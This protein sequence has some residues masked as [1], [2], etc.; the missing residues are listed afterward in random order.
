MALTYKDNMKRFHDHVERL[1]YSNNVT[2]EPFQ[3]DRYLVHLPSG[4]KVFAL[5]S[6]A[7]NSEEYKKFR[8]EQLR[9][10]VEITPFLLE[11]KGP[12]N[13]D[14]KQDFLRYFLSESYESRHNGSLSKYTIDPNNK[15]PSKPYISGMIKISRL[16]KHLCTLKENKSYGLIYFDPEVQE[17][18][19]IIDS[20][21][22]RWFKDVFLKGKPNNDGFRPVNLSKDYKF[23]FKTKKQHPILAEILEQGA[24][25][26]IKHPF[27]ERI[28]RE[29]ADEEERRAN[30][31]LGEL[32]ELPYENSR[33][34]RINYPDLESDT[35][36]AEEE[37]KL[38]SNWDL[39]R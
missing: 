28:S 33:E 20:F 39:S 11:Q 30:E 26:E 27:A 19:Q 35:L 5:L 23:P 34:Q 24:K 8:S 22:N 37:Q 10:G 25:W 36:S 31:V 1:L 17:T 18:E 16:E 6:R 4:T 7:T 9:E 12:Y 38:K 29:Q 21:T 2:Y 14:K 32:T 13:K 3:K 15:E